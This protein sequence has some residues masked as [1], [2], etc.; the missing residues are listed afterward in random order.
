MSNSSSGR[1][2][3]PPFSQVQV[4]AISAILADLKSHSELNSLLRQIH[5]SPPDEGSKQTRIVNTIV[6]VQN[7][8][9]D[10]QAV[11]RTIKVIMDPAG[12]ADEPRF[13]KARTDINR[14]LSYANLHLEKTGRIHHSKGATTM[15]EARLRANELRE[16]LLAINADPRVLAYCD[17]ELTKESFF[18]ACFEA[19]KSVAER[20]R[21][22]TGKT[23]DGTQLAEACLGGELPAIALNTLTTSSDK[24]EQQGI[25]RLTQG[26]FLAFR[27]QL[28]HRPRAE[29]PIDLSEA[30]HLLSLASYIHSRLDKRI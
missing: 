28:A 4:L 8:E 15:S 25:L 11:L 6:E 16:R 1:S 10:G 27:N 29:W 14:Q 17:E 5:P 30:V 23:L 22:M 3:V 13:E 19:T 9:R 26:L 20:L 2:Q 24:A 12:H 7:R 21:K 18:H